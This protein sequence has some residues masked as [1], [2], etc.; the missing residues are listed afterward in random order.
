MAE[1]SSH[2]SY[3]QIKEA[4]QSERMAFGS[5]EESELAHSVAL[6]LKSTWRNRSQEKP[7]LGKDIRTLRDP[8][9]VNASAEGQGQ[10]DWDATV[11][12]KFEREVF[13]YPQPC[14]TAT[15][16]KGKIL[17]K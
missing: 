6:F 10:S 8:W 13:R 4:E 5:W 14:S 15:W 11:G 3:S 7:G 17:K 12:G 1:L 2:P 16:D 9:G